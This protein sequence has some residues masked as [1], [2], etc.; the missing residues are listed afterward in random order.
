MYETRP[1]D[2]TPV[3]VHMAGFGAR[4]AGW[5]IDG[6]LLFVLAI[7][8]GGLGLLQ[9]MAFN[10]A[11]RVAYFVWLEGGASGQTLGKRLAGIR[12]ADAV[13]GGS[14]GRGRA[15][16]RHVGR[17]FSYFVC[18]L[19]FLWMLWDPQKQTWH[20]KMASSVVLRAGGLGG[21]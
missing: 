21:G 19:G 5:V 7:P 16:V 4:S 15:L 8:F 14:I 20:D 9:L 3:V 17:W 12:V 18:G 13:T 11:L 1:A 6:I 2:P 10:L